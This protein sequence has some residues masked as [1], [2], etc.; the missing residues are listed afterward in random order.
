MSLLKQFV[1]SALSTLDDVETALGDLIPKGKSLFGEHKHFE[2]A[3][4]L[5][6]G[7]AKSKKTIQESAEW[8]ERNSTKSS[9]ENPSNSPATSADSTGGETVKRA[10]KTSEQ[11]NGGDK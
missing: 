9:S 11:S 10:S 5:K 6:D 2:T 7:L 8:L 4:K 1:A 3:Q